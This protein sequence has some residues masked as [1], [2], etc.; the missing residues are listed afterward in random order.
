MRTVKVKVTVLALV[1]ALGLAGCARDTEEALRV[2]DVSVANSQV[3]DSAAPFVGV[4]GA[5]APG[6]SGTETVAQVRQSVVQLTAFKEVASRYARETGVRPESPDYAGAAQAFQLD[7]DD[8]Y[9]RLN[10]EAVALRDAL[11]A[12]ATGR[13]PTEDE[14]RRV[15]DDFIALAGAGAA[16]FDQIRNELLG[17]PEYQQALA[18]RDELIAAADRY[19]VTVNP[20][21]Q[22]LEFPLIQVSDGQLTLVSVPLGEQGTGAT[23]PQS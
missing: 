15:Y 23:R 4:L 21:Y 11:L 20:R 8:P 16:T 10:A 17:F 2:G 13:Q 6:T 7:V 19:G 1:A 9:V 3:E 12:D 22:P 5:D 18:L 14:I